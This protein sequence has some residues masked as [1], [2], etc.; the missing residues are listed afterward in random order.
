MSPHAGTRAATDP[1]A[2]PSTPW[3]HPASVDVAALSHTGAVRANNEDS[4][5]V[6]R[7]GRYLEPIA[8]NVPVAELPPRSE[9]VAWLTMIAD[10]VGGHQ[11]GEVASRTA[12]TTAQQL[13]QRSPQWAMRLDDPATRPTQIAEMFA[14]GRAYVAGVQKTLR[15]RIADEPGLSGMATTLTGAYLLGADLFVTHVGDSK[16]YLVR[17]G[18]LRKITRDHTLAQEYA[19]HGMIAQEEVASHQLHH[20]LTRAVD[21]RAENVEA[22]FHHVELEPGDRVL[23]CS[24]GLT[25]M[26]TEEAIHATLA[27][28]EASEEACRALVAL[29]LEGGGRDNITVVVMGWRPGGAA[30]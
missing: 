10:G 6:F 19:D 4:Y 27:R 24:D 2:S 20:V 14:R 25:D 5:V 23:L 22:D 29:A 11:A 13:I 12:L 9:D 28:H 30:P 8:S 7:L 3:W 17:G 1:P 15:A 16:A 21:E 18:R 26:A